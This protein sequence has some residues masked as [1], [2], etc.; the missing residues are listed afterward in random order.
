MPGVGVIMEAEEAPAPA[1]ADVSEVQADIHL[2]TPTTETTTTETTTTETTTTE[3]TTT[4]T[5]NTHTTLGVTLPTREPA[6][7]YSTPFR[8]LG[9]CGTQPR[10]LFS[11]ITTKS[12]RPF[13]FKPSAPKEPSIETSGHDEG[14]EL[15]EEYD[16]E[17]RGRLYF[18]KHYLIPY[19]EECEEIKKNYTGE[20]GPLADWH[21]ARYRELL[22]WAH[23][24]GTGAGNYSS[25]LLDEFLA[26]P[27]FAGDSRP[28]RRD[29]GWT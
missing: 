2:P 19:L 5:N 17:S 13:H 8:K 22:Q 27:S 6:V 24:M 20:E 4:E 11:P 9:G 25:G 26:K 12:R 15:D 18:A 29:L 10:P 28:N 3:T 14:M 23:H 7:Y 1:S 16:E 21:R